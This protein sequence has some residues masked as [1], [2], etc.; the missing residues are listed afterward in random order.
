M[1]PQPQGSQAY[2]M[3]ISRGHSTPQGGIIHHVSADYVTL[4]AILT[5]SL[6]VETPKPQDAAVAALALTYARRIDEGE[7]LTKLGPSLLGALEA[8]QMSPRARAAAQKGMTNGRPTDSRLDELR[9]RR[10]RKHAA[11]AGDAAAT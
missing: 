3:A 2:S 4:E 1:R 6:E 5:A 11:E 8:L 9:K 10:A 7:D